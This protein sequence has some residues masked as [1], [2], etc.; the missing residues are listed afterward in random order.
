MCSQRHGPEPCSTIA[1]QDR[2]NIDS[3]ESPQVD[4]DDLILDEDWVVLSDVKL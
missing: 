1:G 2:L 3:F 4:D